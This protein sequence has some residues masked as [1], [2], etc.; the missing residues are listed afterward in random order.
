M[1]ISGFL[2]FMDLFVT[3]SASCRQIV[4]FSSFAKQKKKKT[5]KGETHQNAE[6]HCGI[7]HTVA[8]ALSSSPRTVLAWKTEAEAV[9]GAMDYPAWMQGDRE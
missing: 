1:I 6:R 3:E 4:S 2:S 7:D 9:D 5:Q 8:S